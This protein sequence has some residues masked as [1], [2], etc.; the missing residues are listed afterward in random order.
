MQRSQGSF[1]DKYETEPFGLGKKEEN[2]SYIYK[3]ESRK[4]DCLLLQAQPWVRGGG[5]G[6]KV[7]I[8]SIFR[9]VF[10]GH[11]Q[12]SYSL[13]LRPI[14]IDYIF[15]ANESLWRSWNRN[16]SI[17]VDLS[18]VVSW[19]KVLRKIKKKKIYLNIF[20]TSNQKKLFIA[21]LEQTLCFCRY[22]SNIRTWK[23]R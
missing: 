9:A 18:I 13:W 10:W 17:S 22:I 20:V 1:A 6:N 5:G 21:M 11:K 19:Q 14:H 2:V 3:S 7:T 15:L 8:L 4:G 12:S 16:K 23:N